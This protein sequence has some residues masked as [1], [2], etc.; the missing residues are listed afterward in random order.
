MAPWLLIRSSI[1]GLTSR[2]PQFCS[3]VGQRTHLECQSSS[4]RPGFPARQTRVMTAGSNKMIKL[5]SQLRENWV[6]NTYVVCT[7]CQPV[8]QPLRFDLSE[9]VA[10]KEAFPSPQATCNVLDGVTGQP[11][12]SNA[13][14][15]PCATSA[16]QTAVSRSRARLR[17]PNSWRRRSFGDRDGHLVSN[18]PFNPDALGLCKTV[19]CA[20]VATFA[21]CAR[22]PRFMS[23]I[24]TQRRVKGCLPSEPPCN[25]V[26][27]DPGG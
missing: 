23:A 5:A 19:K 25:M 15:N 13:S 12:R 22:S 10:P 4:A 24:R 6:R 1:P 21:A 14:R 27:L 2:E 3:L 17:L 20:S 9:E 18:L 11:A 26:W 16:G 7:L 8:Q